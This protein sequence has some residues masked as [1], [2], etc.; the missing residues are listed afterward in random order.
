VYAC[1]TEAPADGVDAALVD[2]ARGADLL[3]HDAQYL[4]EEYPAK[5]GWG[6]STFAA[7]AALAAAAGVRRLVLTHHDP[8]R[9]DLGVARLERR[10]RRRF[11]A[12]IAAREGLA[13]TLRPAAAVPAAGP[14]PAVAGDRDAA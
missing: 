5:V 11:P 2:L 13:L 10:A 6:H 4:P 12:V 7:A 8:A 1:D 9:D 3:I 14:D